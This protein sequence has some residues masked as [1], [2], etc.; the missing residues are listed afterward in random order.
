MRSRTAA[1]WLVLAACS[2]AT[3]TQQLGNVKLLTETQRLVATLRSDTIGVATMRP[4][5][6]KVSVLERQVIII[7]PADAKLLAERGDPAVLDDLL[8]L[9]DDPARAWAAEVVFAKLTQSDGKTIDVYMTRPDQWWK[10]FG[11]SARSHRQRWLDEH[12][13]R[14]VWNVKSRVFEVK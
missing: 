1:A 13:G 2:N 3:E 7:G 10:T 5:G 6:S 4:P 9:L 8:P 14:L 12:R 11:P